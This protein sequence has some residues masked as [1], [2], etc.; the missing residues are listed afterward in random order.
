MQPVGNAM[1][2]CS[3]RLHLLE[4]LGTERNISKSLLKQ[5]VTHRRG[6]LRNALKSA[7]SGQQA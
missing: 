3:E 7:F 5:L 2:Y 4:Y 1:V 6:N